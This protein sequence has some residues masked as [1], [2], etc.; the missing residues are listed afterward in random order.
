[1]FLQSLSE[2]K[3]LL[4]YFDFEFRRVPLRRASEAGDYPPDLGHQR[5]RAL[6]ACLLMRNAVLIDSI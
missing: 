2:L 1:M 3:N 4:V 5:R 6:P